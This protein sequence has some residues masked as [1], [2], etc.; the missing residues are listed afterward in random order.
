MQVNSLLGRSKLQEGG[1]GDSWI[2]V[3][4]MLAD[5]LKMIVC[6]TNW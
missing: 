2:F 5:G 3:K 6:S 1:V 4:S